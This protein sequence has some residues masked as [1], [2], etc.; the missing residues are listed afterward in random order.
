MPPRFRFGVAAILVCAM[1]VLST[2]TAT[3]DPL[4]SWNDGKLKKSIMNFVTRVTT[5]G[6]KD[7]VPPAERIA[8]FDN[9]GTLWCEQPMYF[10]NR[11]PPLPATHF[12][13]V[14][15]RGSCGGGG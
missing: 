7:F 6:I 2:S 9:D 5:K 8:T 4:L 14:P 13:A 11:S 3:A 15:V 10:R 12:P 1:T